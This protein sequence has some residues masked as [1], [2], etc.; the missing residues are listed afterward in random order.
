VPRAGAVIGRSTFPG[1]ERLIA[2]S[3]RFRA[4]HLHILGGTGTGK[5]TLLANLL[6]HDMN[7]GNGVFL[8]DPKGDLFLAALARVPRHRIK[9]VIVIDI[10]DTEHVVGFNLL[11]DGS[12]ERAVSEIIKLFEARYPDMRRGVWAPAGFF[13]GLTTLAGWEGAAFCDIVPLLSPQWTTDPEAR[14]RED[15]MKSVRDRNIATFWQRYLNEPPQRQDAY[16]APVIDRAWQ[17]N[18]RP[19]LRNIIGQSRSTFDMRDVAS[20]KKLLFVNLHGDVDAEAAK[21]LGTM[22]LNSFRLAAMNRTDRR[23]HV[24][25]YIDEFPDLMHLAVPHE[26]MLAKFRSTN[27]GLTLAHQDMGQLRKQPDL[28]ST[29]LANARNKIIFN[30]S[31]SDA[32]IF[33]DEFRGQ[34][35]VDDLIYLSQYEAIARVMTDQGVSDPMTLKTLDYVPVR[36]TAVAVRLQSRLHYTRSRFDVEAEILGRRQPRSKPGKKRQPRIGDMD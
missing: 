13:R 10:R 36:G 8:V 12:P 4:Q 18:E 6:T 7:V 34:V 14:W 15:V 1:N 21:L 22:L 17:F 20:G 30:V 32:R 33:A 23:T 25:V 35:T 2:L 9:D 27:T 26:E 29:I 3:P 28:M 31:A 5:T 11:R 16:A 24:Q 19:A